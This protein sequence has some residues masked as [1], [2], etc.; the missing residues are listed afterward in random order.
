MNAM[1]D[2]PAT[3]PT[4]TIL[5]PTYQESAAI[6][7]CLAAIERQDYPNIVET[8]VVDGRSEDDTRERAAA[9]PGVTVLDNPD[10]VQAFALNVGIA[11]AKGDVIV[12][13]D[14]HCT[15][16]DDYVSRCVDALERTGAAM[17][18]GGMTPVATSAGQQGIAAAMGSRFGAGPARFHV[19]GESGWVDTVYLGAYRTELAREV[20]GYATDVG[21]NED[22]EFAI[23]M[24]LHGGV[25]FDPEIRSTY[26]PRGSLR[27]VAK[28]FY[29][30]GRSRS[31]TAL[32]HPTS[33]RPRQLIAP[34]LVVGLAS[35]RRRT[36]AAAYAVAVVAVAAREKD[37]D[38]RSRATFAASLPAMHLSWGVGFLQGVAGGVID[39][40]RG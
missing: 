22:A 37:L 33:V 18:G 23:R 19:G 39:R 29:R 24:E 6:D 34:A 12:R 9:H 40:V 4:V 31:I 26:V 27:A 20:G 5:I 15:I 35:R 32:R 10:R 30:Y 8:L 38:A 36:V 3:G 1:H 28:Q 16:A 11:A 17:V 13:V 25:Y 7:G 2:A 21:V 14:G